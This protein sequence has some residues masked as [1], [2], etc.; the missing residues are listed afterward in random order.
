[1]FRILFEN[2]SHWFSFVCEIEKK[3]EHTQRVPKLRTTFISAIFFEI[4]KKISII[5]SMDVIYDK[6]RWIYCRNC[7]YLLWTIFYMWQL[8]ELYFEPSFWI[9]F[10]P[11]FDIPSAL[12]EFNA[13][14]SINF[15]KIS[16]ICAE[17][18]YGMSLSFL[19][20]LDSNGSGKS[21]FFSFFFSMEKV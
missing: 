9:F 4:F 10:C 13:C 8:P 11:S 15:T 1:M 6:V 7:E 14:K 21:V 20:W 3:V 2:P 5:I 17:R 16:I 18:K 12:I 19:L